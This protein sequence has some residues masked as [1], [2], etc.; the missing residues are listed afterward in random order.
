MHPKEEQETC[1][2]FE[3]R[4]QICLYPC[5]NVAKESKV[6]PGMRDHTGNVGI[7]EMAEVLKNGWIFNYPPAIKRGVMKNPLFMDDV[8]IQTS[9]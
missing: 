9:I 2:K 6:D 1:S 8:P 7:H 4:L 5:G 3:H